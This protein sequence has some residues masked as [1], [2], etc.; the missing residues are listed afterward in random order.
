MV[1]PRGTPGSRVDDLLAQ[2]GER[3]NVAVRVPHFLVAPHVVATTDLVWT[4]PA[5][6]ARVFVEHLPLVIREPP[7]R[8]E[9]FT[10]AMR[11]HAR[12]AS[13]P[14]LVWLRGVLREVAPTPV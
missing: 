3:R 11:W 10:V 2:A 14:G 7:L 12:L 1:A 4:A 8:I 6:I 9:G 5:S 13:D